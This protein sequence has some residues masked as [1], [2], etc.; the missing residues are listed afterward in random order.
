M[1]VNV[2]PD[3]RNDCSWPVSVVQ[4]PR[5]GLS[6]IEGQADF[7]WTSIRRVTS[8]N[9]A[10]GHL[11]EKHG[12]LREDFTVPLSAKPLKTQRRGRTLRGA[13]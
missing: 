3:S 8:A 1:P 11:L 12:K 10:V 6:G 2:E 9:Q 4:L 13:I 5:W 7:C